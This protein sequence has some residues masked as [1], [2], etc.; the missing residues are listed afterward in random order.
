MN[1]N[2]PACRHQIEDTKML[3]YVR[4]EE[5]RAKPLLLCI[6]S[7]KKKVFQEERKVNLIE[8]C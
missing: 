6:K 4:Q 3:K 8:C 7:P 2:K 5:N 1:S